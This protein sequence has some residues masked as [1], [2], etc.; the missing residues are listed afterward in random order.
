MIDTICCLRFDNRSGAL[1]VQNFQKLVRARGADAKLV[2]ERFQRSR[3]NTSWRLLS[4]IFDTPWLISEN[5][6]LASFLVSSHSTHSFARQTQRQNSLFMIKHSNA[7][8][9]GF[10]VE[11]HR[12]L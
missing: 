9:I 2:I 4:A 11:L 5:K 1:R 3:C 10:A 12:R 6:R 7:S 8:L